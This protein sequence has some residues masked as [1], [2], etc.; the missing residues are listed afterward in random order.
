MIFFWKFWSCQTAM[1]DRMSPFENLSKGDIRFVNK[2][3]V[4]TYE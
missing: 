1:H 3:K 2:S 4:Y